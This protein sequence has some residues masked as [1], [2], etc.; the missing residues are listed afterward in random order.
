MENVISAEEYEIL[1]FLLDFI[2]EG[3]T[4]CVVLQNE[5]EN[6]FVTGN[7]DLFNK[8]EEDLKSINKELM[9][10]FISKNMKSWP[11]DAGKLQ[12]EVKI[13]MQSPEE[14]EKAFEVKGQ[15]GSGWESFYEKYP[16]SDG[17][18]VIS[19]AGFNV[20]KTEALVYI[21]GMHDYL[22]AEGNLYYL[23]KT[24]NKWQLSDII[25]LWIS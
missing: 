10:D 23:K 19:R 18:T 7:V 8:Q 2:S 17:Q 25:P 5:T 6:D 13:L 14:L 22:C 20:K 15:T 3:E 1:G 9:L 16:E 12:T 11:L 4:E 24:D 21:A